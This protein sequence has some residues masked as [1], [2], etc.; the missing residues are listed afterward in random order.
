MSEIPEDHPRATSLKIRHKLIE[1][2]HNN[3]V[4]E[5]GLIAHGRGEAYD[6]LIGEKTHDFALQ[7]ISAAAALIYISDHPV[8]SINGNTAILCPKEMIKFSKICNVPMEINLF[9]KSP[10][11]LE[12]ISNHLKNLGATNLLGI[13]EEFYDSIEQ[14]SS[15]RRI[16]DNRGI[17]IADTV[18][19]PLEDGDRTKALK[20]NHKKVITIDLNPLSRTA[21]QADITIVDNVIQVFP[22]LIEK[23]N[24]ITSKTE[25]QTI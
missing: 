20:N 11:R 21:Q 24:N 14:L 13:D 17:K 3:I 15:Y 25:A 1:G 9:Y 19:V 16:A 7:S 6:Y 4:T 5:A 12:A 23:Y 22:I 2:M 18:I 10:G 8:L